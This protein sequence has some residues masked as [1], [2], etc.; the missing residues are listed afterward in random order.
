MSKLLGSFNVIILQCLRLVNVINAFWKA[1]ILKIN[2]FPHL[3]PF[4]HHEFSGFRKTYSIFH[5]VLGL[6]IKLKRISYISQ[7]TL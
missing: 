3:S 1:I 7:I 4:G 6:L 5:G 2:L